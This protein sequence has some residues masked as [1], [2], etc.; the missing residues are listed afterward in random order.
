MGWH[1]ALKAT[2]VA[3]T[4]LRN[5]EPLPM[6]T[7]TELHEIRGLRDRSARA[8]SGMVVVEGVKSV[9]ELCRS[10]WKVVRIYAVPERFADLPATHAGVVSGCT[11]RDMERMSSLRTAPGV[12]ALA[13]LPEYAPVSRFDAAVCPVILGLDGIADPGNVGT[14]IRTALWFGCAE[15]WVDSHGADPWSAKSIQAAMGATFHIPIREVDLVA[16]VQEASLPCWVLDAGGSDVADHS[17]KPGI[18]C[19]GSESHGPSPDLLAAAS[20]V[21]GIPGSG[22]AESLNAAVAGGIVLAHAARAFRR[23]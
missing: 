3:Q 11:H 15:V 10:G 22:Q 8:A 6:P 23:G 19:V 20:G 4:Y 12:L 21:L 7:R 14:L 18:V 13:E 2:T 16:A 17:W 9:A 1:P 5:L